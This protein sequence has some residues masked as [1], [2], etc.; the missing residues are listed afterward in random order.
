M[1]SAI[2]IGCIA[3]GF[4]VLSALACLS[5]ERP[6]ETVGGEWPLVILILLVEWAVVTAPFWA[7]LLGNR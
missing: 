3:L 6:G 5:D 7:P 2:T 1:T 4:L